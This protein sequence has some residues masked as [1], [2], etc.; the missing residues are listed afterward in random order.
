[1]TMLAEDDA[2]DGG[3]RANVSVSGHTCVKLR[4]DL[5]LGPHFGAASDT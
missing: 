1:M 5:E 2:Q 3:H 4:M